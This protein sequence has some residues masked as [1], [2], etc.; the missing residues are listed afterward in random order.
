MA[1]ENK[2]LN[3]DELFG[4][5]LSV[6]VIYDGVKH[7]LVRLEALD[8]RQAVRFQKLQIKARQLQSINAKDPS[9]SDADQVTQAVDEMLKILC[10][11]LPLDDPNLTF[12][13]KTRILEY[14]FEKAEK[15]KADKNALAKMRNQQIGRKSS[16]R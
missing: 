11:S 16:R 2:P 15:K 7:E 3:L 1:D 6:S 10:S 14:Y 8:P 4:T 12:I 13:K 5:A 9:D